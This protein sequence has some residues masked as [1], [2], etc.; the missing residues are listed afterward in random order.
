MESFRDSP[1]GQIIRFLT[2]NKYLQYPEEEPGFVVPIV[3]PEASEKVHD[4]RLSGQ[5]STN[6]SNSGRRRDAVSAQPDDATLDL[7]KFPSD[8][9]LDSRLS[10]TS[11]K[12]GSS[13][14]NHSQSLSRH[15]T[16][17]GN[18]I[19]DWY[20]PNDPENPQ[21]WVLSKKISVTLVLQAY[22]LVVYCAS[23][24]YTPS[25][26]YVMEDFDVSL[27]KASLGLSMYVLGYGFG[28]ILFSP[29]SEI[30]RIGRNIPYIT[31]FTLFVILAVPTALTPTYGSLLA[32]RFLTGFLGSPCLA[33]GG[34]TLQEM[35]SIIKLPYALS[36]WV[37]ATFSA[38]ALGPLLSGFAVPAKGW[39]WS[40]WEILWMSAPVLIL[41]YMAFPETSAANILLRRAQRLRKLTGNDKYKSQSELDQAN[42]NP[43]LLF[44]NLYTAYIYGIFYSFFESF[45]RVYIAIY[46][47][48]L[49]TMGVAFLVILVACCIGAA[50]YCSYIY[51][52]LEPDIKKNGFRAQEHRLVPA[53]FAAVLQPAGLFIFAWTS[54]ED[55]HWM[56]GIVGLTL[57]GVGSFIL[58]QCI[59]MY[60]P[61][62]YPQYAA[63]LFAAN[64][65]CRSCLAAGAI[66]FAQPLF[67]NLGIDKGVTL[68]AGLACGGVVGIW[69]IWYWGAALRA[70]SKFALK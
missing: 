11:G 38:P 16:I 37:G 22:T 10:G 53:I 52:Y 62:S 48:N 31:S 28:P 4:D 63:S 57:Y 60:L 69:A 19:V 13:E 7:E 50:I 58:F 51:W 40:L 25:N 55:V 12:H 15:M 70:R 59:F 49:G 41:M 32:L 46:G 17:D 65:L 24:I 34:A 54:R 26:Q 43:A 64:D 42:L 68:L 45:P 21:N 14:R 8:D 3:E 67:D 56:A 33:T 5:S 27:I 66:I 20:G 23:A 29:L 30:P 1:L 18:I 35:Y 47:F 44:V 2:S 36:A 39:R 9:A 61:L 6:G